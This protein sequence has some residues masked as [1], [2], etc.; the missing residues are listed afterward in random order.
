MHRLRIELGER[1]YPILIGPALLDD[2]SRPRGSGGG[3]R[4]PR[5]HQRDG[6]A[7]VPRPPRPLVGRQAGRVRRAARRRA[8]QDPRHA[9]ARLRRARR[10]PDEPRCLRRRARRRRRRRHRGFRGGLLPARRRLRAGADDAARAG[11]LLGRRQDR[12]EPP[13]RQEPDRRLPPAAGRRHGHRHAGDAAGA[14]TARR[15]GR[16]DQVRAGR[17]RDFPRLD[18]GSSRRAARSRRRGR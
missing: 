4:R 12:G 9:G 7:A 8:I 3:T 15:A 17:R 6:G 14:R 18:R 5:G 16:G 10:A 11:G 1:G 2:P 13:G